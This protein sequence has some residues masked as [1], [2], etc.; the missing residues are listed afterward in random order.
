MKETT[1]RSL[2]VQAPAD[3]LRG[4][5]DDFMVNSSMAH[6]PSWAVQA[7]VVLVKD[8]M[9][10]PPDL[11]GLHLSA[12]EVRLS[13][14]LCPVTRVHVYAWNFKQSVH[15]WLTHYGNERVQIESEISK[16]DEQQEMNEEVRIRETLEELREATDEAKAAMLDKVDEGFDTLEAMFDTK[17]IG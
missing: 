1:A 3:I 17:D 12:E 5:L 16:L 13:K 4:A 2:L 9:D 15:V 10:V 7:A 6:W 14:G 11:D 8:D